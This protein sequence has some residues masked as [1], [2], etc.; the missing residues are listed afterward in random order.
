MSKITK[1]YRICQLP[2]LSCCESGWCCCCCSS[3]LL[4]PLP[5]WLRDDSLSRLTLK[6]T[7]RFSEG[8]ITTS[9]CSSAS[10]SWL[11]LPAA[12]WMLCSAASSWL[13]V[14][15]VVSA[16]MASEVLLSLPMVRK[17]VHSS[18]VGSRYSIVFRKTL[19]EKNIIIVFVAREE[20]KENREREG[21]TE[22]QREMGRGKRRLMILMKF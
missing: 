2:Q 9:G 20:G 13:V 15:V 6:V 5:C 17:V 18:Q 8:V 22:R 11:L 1:V 12:S 3:S 7:E 10:A 21:E 16:G 14:V 19:P 4:L